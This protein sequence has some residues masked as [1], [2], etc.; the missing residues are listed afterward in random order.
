MKG[1]NTA[2]LNI[3]LIHFDTLQ[4]SLFKSKLVLNSN[5]TKFMLF[6]KAKT[7]GT[8]IPPLSTLDGTSIEKV[9]KYKYLGLWLDDNLSFKHHVNDLASR[10]RQKVGFLY[11]NRSCFPPICRKRI[12]EAVF[13][14]V[15]RCIQTKRENKIRIALLA[16]V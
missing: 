16:R 9:S 8:D 7:T 5:K 14:S 3:L 12:I 15:S 4:T 11:R 10:L 6:S 2:G 1:Y 13:M